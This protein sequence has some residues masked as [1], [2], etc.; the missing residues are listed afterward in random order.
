MISLLKKDMMLSRKPMMLIGVLVI[1]WT[2]PAFLV[3]SEL[4]GQ[5]VFGYML[6]FQ[7]YYLAIMLTQQDEA[8]KADLII[9]S[10]PVNRSLVV[11]ERYLY[12]MVQPAAMSVFILLFSRTVWAIPAPG[13]PQGQVF[14]TAGAMIVLPVIWIALSFYLPVNYLSIGKIKVFNQLSFMALILLPGIASRFIK[15]TE[16]PVWFPRL[17]ELSIETIIGTLLLA[18]LIIYFISYKIS[19]KIYKIKDFY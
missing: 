3:Q 2:I 13:F 11:A 10:L 5:V 7:S 15:N 14:S 19:N 18:S 1:V 12:F 17:L 6:F 16:M 4:M 9:N 8:V